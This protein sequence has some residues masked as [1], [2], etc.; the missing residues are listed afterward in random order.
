MLSPYPTA[1]KDE[2]SYEFLTDQG[3]KYRIHFLD[4]SYMFADYPQLHCPFYSFNIDAIEGDP[5]LIPSDER[6]GLT[7]LE[8]IKLFFKNVVNVAIYVCD[9]MDQRQYARKRK[10]D[11]WFFIYND[12]HCIV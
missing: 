7:V 9:S 2:F 11:S 4:Y 3:V 5:D 12:G 8:I 1:E 6:I 10:F